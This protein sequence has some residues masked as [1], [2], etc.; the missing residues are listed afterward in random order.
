MLSIVICDDDSTHIDILKEHL[1]KILQDLN[2]KY[3]ILEFKSGEELVENYPGKIDILFLDI[4]MKVLTGMDVARRIREFDTKVEIIF[5]T[6]VADYVHEG[7]EVRAYR[8]LLKPIKYENLERHVKL[9][10]K[11]LLSKNSTISI[12]SNHNTVVLSVDEILYVEVQ[13]KNVTIH[14]EQK[15][16]VIEISMKKVE[17]KLLNH[18]FFRCHKSFLVNLRKINSIK[19]KMVIIK[20][21]E[22]P[23]SRYKIKELKIQLANVLG[24]VLC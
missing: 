13:K 15:D 1:I 5:T 11:D 10:I 8:Y 12:Q 19:D 22:V 17:E 7:Y 24:D 20:G 3:N 2:M 21:H 14:T 16:Y 23:V 4:Q 9:C 18:K 6:A